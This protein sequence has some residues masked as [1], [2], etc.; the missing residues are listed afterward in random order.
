MAFVPARLG[1]RGAATCDAIE[2]G[3]TAYVHAVAVNDWR[4]VAERFLGWDWPASIELRG[5]AIARDNLG[6][7]SGRHK[8]S[9]ALIVKQHNASSHE[10]RAG[11]DRHGVVVH[12]SL[13]LHFAAIEHFPAL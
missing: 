7:G 3:L 8:H 6:L 12:E 5:D 13:Q 11:G 2:I 10:R 9:R 1:S 4:G